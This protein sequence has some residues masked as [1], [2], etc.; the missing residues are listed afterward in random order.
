MNTNTCPAMYITLYRC[1]Q[2]S[3]R[4]VVRSDRAGFDYELA[5]AMQEVRLFIHQVNEEHYT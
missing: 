1:P 3:E 4:W 2:C 5:R